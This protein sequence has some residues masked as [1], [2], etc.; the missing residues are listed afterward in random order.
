MRHRV[1]ALGGSWDVRSPGS[2]GTVVTALIPL[3]KMLLTE[4]A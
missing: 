1:T 3:P 2:R 4:V